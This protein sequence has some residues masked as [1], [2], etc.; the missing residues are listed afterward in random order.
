MKLAERVQ[1][2]ARSSHTLTNSHVHPRRCARRR[3]EGRINREA[4]EGIKD[5][6]FLAVDAFVVVWDWWPGAL[7][8]HR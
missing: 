6:G 7:W 1:L 4:V 3:S 2:R 5:A 8:T